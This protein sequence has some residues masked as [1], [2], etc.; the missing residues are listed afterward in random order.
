TTVNAGTLTLAGGAAL[1]DTMAVTVSAGGL[2]KLAA[3]E[4]LGTV[5]G[6]GN[7]NLQGN[8]LTVGG[9]ATGAGN[10]IAS[11]GGYGITAGGTCTG[12]LIQGNVITGNALGTVNVRNAKG[13]RVV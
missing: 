7:V 9:A 12:S 10:L 5:A 8:T 6:A 1:L 3:S 11:N 4:T 13:I 2:L